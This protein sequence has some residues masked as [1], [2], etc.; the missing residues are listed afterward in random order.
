MFNFGFKSRNTALPRANLVANIPNRYPF[1]S[2]IGHDG[3]SQLRQYAEVTSGTV[4]L[5]H[6][7]IVGTETITSHG[8]TATVSAV[9]G[10]IT[11]GV[12]TCWEIK[13][14]AGHFWTHCA[15][16]SATSVVMWD[17]SGLGDHLIAEGLAE[18]VVTALCSTS[19]DLGI[20][21]D[22]LDKGFTVADGTQYLHPISGGLIPDDV[23]IPALANGSGCCAWEVV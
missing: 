19:S 7:S 13:D 22:W 8:G 4:T 23:I 6:A 10:G 15:A 14:S 1:T 17:V 9:A 18:A 3:P 16:L 12:G 20:G 21:T 5:Y 2:R 11:I